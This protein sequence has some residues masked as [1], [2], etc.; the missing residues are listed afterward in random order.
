MTL[1][2]NEGYIKGQWIWGWDIMRVTLGDIEYKSHSD[3]VNMRIT[4]HIN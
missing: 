4:L 3:T 2:H 1:G